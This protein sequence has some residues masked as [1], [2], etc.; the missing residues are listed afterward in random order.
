[1]SFKKI[2][3]VFLTMLAVIFISADF[4]KK[5]RLS[6]RLSLSLIDFYKSNIS[7]AGAPQCAFYPSCSIYS[8]E[9]LKAHGLAKG[10]AMSFDR[11]T[12]CNN[13][14]WLYTEVLVDD[15]FKKYDPVPLEGFEFF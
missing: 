1:M 5:G 14:E 12:R 15:E 9:A 11:M 2:I 7:I 4:Y 3:F 13:E 8:K 10:W 6:V